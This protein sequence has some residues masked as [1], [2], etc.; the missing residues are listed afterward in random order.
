[1]TVKNNYDDN[2]SS[3]LSPSFSSPRYLNL[4]EFL[5]SEAD[6]LNQEFYLSKSKNSEESNESVILNNLKKKYGNNRT[7]DANTFEKWKRKYH[8]L[9]YRIQEYLLSNEIDKMNF[10][11]SFVDLTKISNSIEY[12][13]STTTAYKQL[14]NKKKLILDTD[15]LKSLFENKEINRIESTIALYPIQTVGDGNCLVKTYFFI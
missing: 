8:D 5:T 7:I 3:R 2:I 1:M 13:N 12:S 4:V 10:F 9:H 11:T 6:F 15:I 14:L